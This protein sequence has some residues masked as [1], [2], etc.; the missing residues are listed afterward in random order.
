MYNM[1]N[2]KLYGF[3]FYFYCCMSV[4]KFKKKKFIN[5]NLK[6][7]IFRIIIFNLGENK[8]YRLFCIYLLCGLFNCNYFY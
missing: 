4:V 8:L 2:I 5:N 6:I 7:G 1:L 3:V